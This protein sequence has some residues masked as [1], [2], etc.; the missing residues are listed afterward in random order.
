MQRKNFKGK[1]V[2]RKIDKCKEICKLYSDVQY[3]YL[4][5]L[6]DDPDIKEVV[7]NIPLEGSPDEKN[8]NRKYTTDFL[9]IRNNG[10][11]IVRECVD[12]SHLSKP[13]TIRLLDAS[14]KYWLEQGIVDW[15]IV[16]NAK[17]K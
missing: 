14:R 10:N 12:R 7:C 15:R 4:N 5:I 17:E 9:C 2:K 13:M 6:N 8:P 1:C 16:T 3:V 11:K